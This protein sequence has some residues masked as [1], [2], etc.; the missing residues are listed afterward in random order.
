M[1]P[2]FQQVREWGEK[3]GISGAS[4]DVQF[5]RF[6]QE[7]TEIHKAMIEGD[8][9]EFKDSIGDT[10]VTLIMLADTCDINA[11]DC[12]EQAFGVI[13]LRKGLN[14]NGS[15]DRYAKLTKEEQLIC[16][17]KQGSPGSE[18]FSE[19]ILP[20]LCPKDFMND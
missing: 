5:Q 12:L 20:E 7:A 4:P 3:R 6:L 10:I 11:E 13:K 18:Y 19:D 15:F 14:K 2:E 9:H 8:T 16:D 1:I 17:E